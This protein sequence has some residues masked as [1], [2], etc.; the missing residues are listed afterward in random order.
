MRAVPG[1]VPAPK[2]GR[3]Y[4]GERRVRLGDVTPAGR[5]R[6]DAIAR[7][8]QD[9]ASDDV[10]DAGVRGPWVLRRLAVTIDHAPRFD[11][12]VA[13]TTTTWCSGSGSR[14]AERRTTISSPTGVLVE[15]VAL[16]VFVDAVSTSARV[17]TGEPW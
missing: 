3:R 10:A 15:S 17:L 8:L 4:E 2:Q 9:V 12:R 16:W 7:C 1:L 6:L 14:G 13:L 5:L 11:D